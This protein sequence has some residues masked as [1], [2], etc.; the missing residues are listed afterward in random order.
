[1]HIIYN[2]ELEDPRNA[3]GHRQCGQI[4][5]GTGF[6]S[7]NRPQPGRLFSDSLGRR[8]TT[9]IAP[10]SVTFTKVT[11]NLQPAALTNSPADNWSMC[12]R[13]ACAIILN[14]HLQCH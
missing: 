12:P 14:I 11:T 9:T 7:H 2:T 3:A 10:L 1:M 8:T 5:T 13:Q 4:H 6:A